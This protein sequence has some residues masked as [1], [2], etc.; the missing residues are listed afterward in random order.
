MVGGDVASCSNGTG[1]G[2]GQLK[3]DRRLIYVGRWIAADTGRST[4]DSSERSC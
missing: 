1:S 2:T 3:E 4:A